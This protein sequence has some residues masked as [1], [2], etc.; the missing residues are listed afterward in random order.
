MVQCDQGLRLHP[1]SGRRQ[2]RVR[3]HLGGRTSG[4]QRAQRRTSCK[5]CEKNYR[6]NDCLENIKWNLIISLI[7]NLEFRVVCA[8]KAVILKN[9]FGRKM[10]L[11]VSVKQLDEGGQRAARRR[12]R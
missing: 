11:P 3:P 7:R 2:G 6:I 9:L 1:A 4:P 10:L 5:K 8:V 12:D